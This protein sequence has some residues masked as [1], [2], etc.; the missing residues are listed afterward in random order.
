[1]TPRTRL[2]FLTWTAALVYA[3]LLVMVLVRGVG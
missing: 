2:L 1:M 3:G